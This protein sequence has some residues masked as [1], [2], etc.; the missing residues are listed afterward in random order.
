MKQ[1]QF[2]GLLG[3]AAAWPLAA[4]AQQPVLPIVGF[5]HSQLA[6]AYGDRLR[7]FHQGLADTGYVE[8]R[9]VAVEYHSAE[10]EPDRLRALVADLIRRPVAVIVGIQLRRLRPRPQP[11]RFPSSSTQAAIPSTLGLSPA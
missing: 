6:D 11:R 1:R 8:G 4:R 3:G 5:V 9:N 2:I 10:G 7:A